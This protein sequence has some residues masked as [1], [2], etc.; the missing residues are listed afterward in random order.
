MNYLDDL[1]KAQVRAAYGE[2]WDRLAE[3]KVR[4]DP[5]NLF[6]STPNIPPAG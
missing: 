2:S 3:I 4:W 5:N 1:G 6:R